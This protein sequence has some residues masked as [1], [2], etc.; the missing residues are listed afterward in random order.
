MTNIE[1][2]IPLADKILGAWKTELGN[3]Y[4]G[5]KN[6]VYRM[7]NFC[8]ALR[9]EFSEEDREKIIIA[10]CFHDLG[11]WTAK[12]F[13]YLPPSISLAKEY[14]AENKLENW[15]DEIGLMI[16]MH[17][18]IGVYQDPQNPLIEIFRQSDLVD[19]SLGLVKCGLPQ[20][21]IK[22]VKNQF[23]NAGF[24]K[25]LVRISSGWI[26]KHPLKPVPVLKW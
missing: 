7:I 3:D 5:Y 9:Q 6:H 18:K 14:L 19:F 4:Q 13:D 2:Q 10:G 8:F 22:D 17:H 24:H 25:C 20:K 12:T 1:S 21:Y 11:I 16:D 23:P 15:S 26:L